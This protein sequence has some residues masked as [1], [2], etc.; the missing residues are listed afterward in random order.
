MAANLNVVKQEMNKDQFTWFEKP[1][2]LNIVLVRNP[3][4]RGKES[5]NL[6]NDKAIVEV[7]KP[8]GEKE[9][10]DFNITTDPGHTY[11]KNP[12]RSFGTAIIA[13][14]QYP[15][16]YVIGNHKENPNHQA[17]IQNS[18]IKVHRDNNRDLVVNLS[19]STVKWE[20]PLL[21]GHRGFATKKTEFVDEFSAGCW[22]FEDAKDLNFVLDLAKQYEKENSYGNY[23]ITVLQPDMAT[24]NLMFNKQEIKINE[25][26]IDIKNTTPDNLPSLPKKLPSNNLPKASLPPIIK[27]PAPPI[28]PTKNLPSDNLKPHEKE[29]ERL[30]AIVILKFPNMPAYEQAML[31]NRIAKT[32]GTQNKNKNTTLLKP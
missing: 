1:G 19:D 32:L 7:T 16:S 27:S 13:K 10:Y 28:L 11:L 30:L 24:Y 9:Q 5:T 6:F 3:E 8:T 29:V 2:K 14:G 31:K 12:I 26:P 15:Q 21:N 25:T 4:D 23:T 20:N 17:F 18:A 22:V